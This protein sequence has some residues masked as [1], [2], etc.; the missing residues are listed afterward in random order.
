M[1]LM[2]LLHGNAGKEKLGEFLEPMADLTSLSVA[3]MVFVYVTYHGTVNQF[4]FIAFG[5]IVLFFL[6]SLIRLGSFH[7][8]K[9]DRCFVGLPASASTIIILVAA[10]LHFDIVL[11]IILLIVLSLLM[12]SPIRFPKPKI[13]INSVAAILI[14]GTIILGDFLQGVAPLI[15][16]VALI[17]YIIF[18]PVYLRTS[19]KK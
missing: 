10:F 4:L 11:N 3:P 16:L 18:G 12:V 19:T 5:A 9:D 13:N 17:C 7:I 2:V 15:L 1:D 14:L 8:L 6:C